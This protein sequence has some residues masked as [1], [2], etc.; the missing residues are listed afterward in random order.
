M[1]C[2]SCSRRRL[3]GRSAAA[4]WALVQAWGRAAVASS[5]REG[6]VGLGVLLRTGV[7]CLGATGALGG[8]YCVE[9]T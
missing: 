4:G 5:V 1:P 2:L 3:E 9:L 8:A 7:W 6:A